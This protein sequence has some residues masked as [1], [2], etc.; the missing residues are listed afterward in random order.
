MEETAGSTGLEETKNDVV[1]SSERFRLGSGLLICRS[2]RRISTR[3][4]YRGPERGIGSF[5]RS[6]ET[7]AE[8]RSESDHT[9]YFV[10]ELLILSISQADEFEEGPDTAGLK[11][12]ST[13]QEVLEVSENDDAAPDSFADT[14]DQNP[15]DASQIPLPDTDDGDLEEGQAE[16]VKSSSVS[17]TVILP[18]MVSLVTL[19]LSSL[20][21]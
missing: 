19:G 6:E 8:D 15:T 21:C 11:G 7:D 2:G 9:N 16:P 3:A 4:R 13:G 1:V 10:L 12:D 17:S 5:G 20:G 14:D 18:V